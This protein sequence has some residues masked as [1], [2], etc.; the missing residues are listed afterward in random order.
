M[1]L[2]ISH[3]FEYIN[4]RV[5][6]NLYDHRAETYYITSKGDRVCVEDVTGDVADWKSLY[7]R[8]WVGLSGAALSA[9]EKK[10]AREYAIEA[11]DRW[12]QYII[13]DVL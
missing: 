10:M 1:K 5:E 13:D 6:I 3:E 7:Y 8:D 4:G 11:I 2:Y 12:I 9:A